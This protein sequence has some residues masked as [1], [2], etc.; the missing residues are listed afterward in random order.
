MA[1][2][3]V[4]SLQ[5]LAR[6]WHNDPGSVQRALVRLAQNPPTFSYNALFAAVRDMLVLRVPYEQILEGI[7]RIK[8]RE[9]LS[10]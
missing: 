6:N 5:H 3:K 1:N 10:H 4:P 9:A 8:R 2:L 7:R